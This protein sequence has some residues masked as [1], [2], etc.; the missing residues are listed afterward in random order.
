MKTSEATPSGR[1]E[2]LDLIRGVFILVMI[3]GHTL[4]LF[5]SPEVKA[6]AVYQYQDMIHNLTGP[7]FLFAAGAAYVY[8]TRSRWEIF[9]RWGPKLRSRLSK[10]LV[11]L[12]IGFALQV[13]FGTLR[14]TLAETTS[15]QL[16]YLLS[17]NIL[18]CIVFSLLLLQSLTMIVP[19]WQWFF[20]ASVIGALGI[21]FLTPFAWEY[22]Q[23]GPIWLASLLSG[24]SRSIFPLVP[25]A[26]FAFAGAAWGYLH[27]LAREQA[28]EATFLRRCAG[29]AAGLCIAN[30]FVGYLPLPEVY[31]HFWSTSPFSFL[32]RVGILTLIVVGARL[33]EPHIQP[34]L[35]TL[36]VA[37]KQSL[38]IYVLH[39]PILYGSAFNPDTSL[40]K[41]L[42]VPLPV[43]DAVLGWLGLTVLMV[44]VAVWWDWWRED[45]A[46][47]ARGVWWLVVGYYSYRFFLE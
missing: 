27:L 33:A 43:G 14:R 23:Q 36:A 9:R 6:M 32:V 16:A 15:D 46:W 39:L 24:R 13:T 10:W 19:N 21:A 17:L 45:H 42:G 35:S 20:R 37:G 41:A 28:R 5:L 44:A 4:R 40:R 31:S 47:Q 11:V 12:V 30:Y 29:Y 26:G 34:R 7:V 3:E 25:Y 18:Q 2:Y 22:G 8:S 38:L 1:L